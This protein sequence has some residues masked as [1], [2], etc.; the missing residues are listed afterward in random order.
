MDETIPNSLL[1]GILRAGLLEHQQGAPRSGLDT[2]STKL[3]MQQKTL[4][5]ARD[6]KS[7]ATPGLLAA[8]RLSGMPAACYW[9]AA[10]HMLSVTVGTRGDERHCPQW[11]MGFCVFC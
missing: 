8:E 1:E 5:A 3:T 4:A 6:S 9:G 10:P 7:R 11:G 2:P